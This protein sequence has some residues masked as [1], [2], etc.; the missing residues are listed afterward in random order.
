[1][2]VD[3]VVPT[4]PAKIELVPDALNKISYQLTTEDGEV[5]SLPVKDPAFAK[6]LENGQIYRV[7]E[8]VMKLC[9]RD[10]LSNYNLR[11]HQFKT[12]SENK[13]SRVENAKKCL[14]DDI[15]VQ[16]VDLVIKIVSK[17]FF[18]KYNGRVDANKLVC[19]CVSKIC[20]R[21]VETI[22][23]LNKTKEKKST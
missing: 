15:R 8:T 19:R 7:L 5:V 20:S 11:G 18:E 17:S 12:E 3:S 4:I 16:L 6:A 2:L 13:V 14:P 22:K 23:R 1:M 9:L 21:H 10:E